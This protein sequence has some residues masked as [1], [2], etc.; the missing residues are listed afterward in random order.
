MTPITMPAIAP[1][2]SPLLLLEEVIGRVLPLA[3]AGGV[4]ETVV[5]ADTTAVDVKTLP[6]VGSIG[7][8]PAADVAGVYAEV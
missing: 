6:L 3:V 5:V 2:L 7:A 4:N 8:P 1:G